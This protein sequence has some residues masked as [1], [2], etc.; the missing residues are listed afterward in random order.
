V[1]VWLYLTLTH[2]TSAFSHPL[3]HYDS[4]SRL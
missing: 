1:V 2:A 3:A 4:N